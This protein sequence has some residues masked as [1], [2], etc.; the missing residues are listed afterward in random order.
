MGTRFVFL[1]LTLVGVVA[2]ANPHADA[3][4]QNLPP[5]ESTNGTAPDPMKLENTVLTPAPGEP[6][7]LDE[8]ITRFNRKNYYHAYRKEMAAY[9]G[10][11]FGLKDSSDDEDVMNYLLGFSYLL[12]SRQSPKW[13]AGATLSTVGH[14]HLNL[15]KRTIYNE[16]GAFR[17]YYEYGVMHKFVPDE[18]FASFSN[19]DNYLARVGFGM[20]DIRRPPRSVQLELELAVGV[21]DVLVMFTYGYSWGF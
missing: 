2:T 13:E 6:S 9:F 5:D 10:A 4:T 7:N 16:K 14:G 19:W 1:I 11:V 15:S 20:A 18:K 12:P 21:E 17:P 8:M 3:P